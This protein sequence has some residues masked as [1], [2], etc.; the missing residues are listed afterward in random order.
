MVSV[1]SSVVDAPLVSVVVG[2]VS[3]DVAEL[4]VVSVDVA[5]LSG[6]FVPV[7]VGSS[8]VE[9]GARLV[10]VS[11]PDGP[12]DVA[13]SEAVESSVVELDSPSL[14]Q[15]DTGIGTS[16]FRRQP[17]ME[18]SSVKRTDTCVDVEQN[19]AAPPKKLGLLQTSWSAVENVVTIDPNDGSG[20]KFCAATPSLV[21]NC[22]PSENSWPPRIVNR[23]ARLHPMTRFP[24]AS[25][26]RW[27]AWRRCLLGR[28]AT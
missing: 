18:S 13:G 10:S 7:A 19:L 28:A 16:T 27:D 21:E 6:V 17:G 14:S 3:G 1:G 24:S 22:N 4:F 15:K 2:V 26:K 11:L 5:E 20:L 8:V 9:V 25:M 23:A 12:T